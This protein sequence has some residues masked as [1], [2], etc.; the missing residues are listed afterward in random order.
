MTKIY[1]IAIERA[2][3]EYLPSYDW[4][5]FKAQLI[6]E[7]RLNPTAKSPVGASGIAQFMPHTWQDMIREMK[8]PKGTKATDPAYSILAGSYYQAKMINGWT[9]PRPVMDRYCL[10][11]ASYNAGFGNLLKAQKH[12]NGASDYKTII[13]HLRFITGD[14]NSGETTGYAKRI[15]SIY[16]NLLTG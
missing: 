13:S 3:Q 15:L 10:A 8:M 16:S 9:A 11:L 6:Q 1:D 2:V 12:A 7:S 14:K 4:R 5:L